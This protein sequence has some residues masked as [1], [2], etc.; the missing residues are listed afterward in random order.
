[1]PCFNMYWVSAMCQASCR[2]SRQLNIIMTVVNDKG[3]KVFYIH[4][5]NVGKVSHPHGETRQAQEGLTR[6]VAIS[7]TPFISFTALATICYLT[8]LL[9]D[10]FII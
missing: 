7:I 2:S 1:M 9:V 8:Y 4:A 3:Y 5:S 6:E 10:V